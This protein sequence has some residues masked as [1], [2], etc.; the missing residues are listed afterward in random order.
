MT[1]TA[2]LRAE[3]IAR[4][5]RRRHLGEVSLAL[6]PGTVLAVRGSERESATLI[7]TL[8]RTLEPDRGSLV[9]VAGDRELDLAHAG[10]R[11]VAWA[12]R[13]WLGLF[14][15]RVRE[16]PNRAAS[17]AVAGP[18]GEDATAAAVLDGLGV[19]DPSEPVGLLGERERTAVALALAL[20][21]PAAILLLH[22]PLGGLEREA[23]ERAAQLIGDAAAAGS[24]VLAT[25][26]TSD[27]PLGGLEG[28]LGSAP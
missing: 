5:D 15:G 26:A 18:A 23:R 2:A 16:L 17:R 3:G 19:S 13:R 12:R 28:E 24:A 21:R 6:E 11:A 8:F 14:D 25:L 27:E 4:D 22:R 20:H 10:D 7:K 9:L 1:A